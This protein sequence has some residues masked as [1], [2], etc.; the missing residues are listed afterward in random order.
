MGGGKIMEVKIKKVHPKAVIPTYA[1]EY[2][3]GMDL[4]AVSVEID[5][6]GNKVYHTGL[7]FEIPK[8]YAGFI[9][10]RSSNAKKNLWLTNSVGI[11][12]ADYRG[13]VT[14]K[15]KTSL[16][17]PKNLKFWLKS[18]FNKPIND[19]DTVNVINVWD[20]EDYQVG[21]R[22]GQLVIMPFPQI[23]FKEVDKLSETARNTG[24]YGSTG[25]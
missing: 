12:D 25:K 9:F 6:Y 10:P 21:E 3:A 19:D 23:E 8:G 14:L 7:A 17:T 13:E 11:I 15:F 24:G 18:W 4:T 2:S 20:N 1:T 16:R 5:K 22:V